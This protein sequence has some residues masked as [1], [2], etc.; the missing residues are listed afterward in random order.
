MAWP[1]LSL[2]QL[3]TRIAASYRGY[4]KGADVNLRHSPDRALVAVIA[5]AADEDMGFTDRIAKNLF[6]FSAVTEYLERWATFKGVSRKG[7]TTGAGFVQLSG[8]AGY[9]A[10]TG[11]RLLTDSGVAVLTTMVAE[12][13]GDG[14][15][16]V[17]AE[18]EAGGRGGNLGEGVR[19]AFVGTPPGFADTGTVS[20]GFAGGTDA[21]GDPSLS[22]RTQRRFAQP[23]FGGNDQDWQNAAL[24]VP[25]VTRIWTAAAV[26]TP[27]AVT[28]YPLFDDLRANGLPVGA[29]AWFRPGTGTS[30]GT[31]GAG[32][33]RLVLDMLLNAVPKLR[34]VC[35]HLYVTSL[36]ATPVDVVIDNLTNDT[37]EV[38]AAIAAE[39]GRMQKRRAA[40]AVACSRDWIAEAISRA[41]GEDSHD[42]V[43]PAGNTAV[44]LGHVFTIGNITYL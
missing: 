28:L 33:Q 8:T 4:F 35:S 29:D 3:F 19:L 26:P 36:V 12:I 22:L 24:A 25:G 1:R 9:V 43:A 23:S 6:P 13:G 5:G 39:L 14:T 31:G 11:Q 18:A 27:G 38:R 20:T 30:A 37:P 17:T 34:P 21:E 15:V 7:A 40:P 44:P 16:I 42:L 41:A 10:D 32:D 2:A